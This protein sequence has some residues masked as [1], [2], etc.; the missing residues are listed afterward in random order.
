MTFIAEVAKDTLGD[1]RPDLMNVFEIFA[2]GRLQCIDGTEMLAQDS[3]HTCSNMADSQGKEQ[4]LVGA[5][6]A[7]LDAIE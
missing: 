7:R 6:F 1:L 5:L 4:A 3:D 2:A